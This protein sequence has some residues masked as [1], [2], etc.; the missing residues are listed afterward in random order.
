MEV[1]YAC[2]CGL[3]V[4]KK[5]ITACVLCAEGKGKARKEKQRFGTFTRELLQLA[6]W[7]RAC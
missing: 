2:C 5:S 1:L 7:L 3:D 6:D 4:H